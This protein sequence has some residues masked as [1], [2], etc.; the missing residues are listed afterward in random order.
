[1]YAMTAFGFRL[2]SNDFDTKNAIRYGT[3]AVK[4]STIGLMSRKLYLGK[5]G[6]N[7]PGRIQ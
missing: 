7:V 3:H 2:A 6:V 4:V 1:M 5:T